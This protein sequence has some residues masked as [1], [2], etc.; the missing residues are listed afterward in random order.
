MASTKLC[1]RSHVEVSGPDETSQNI[2]EPPGEY[3]HQ[4]WKDQTSNP[5]LQVCL[6]HGKL[7]PQADLPFDVVLGEVLLNLLGEGEHNIAGCGENEE[8]QPMKMVEQR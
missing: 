2:F 7:H 1:K 4:H 6:V 3:G 8:H 5:L